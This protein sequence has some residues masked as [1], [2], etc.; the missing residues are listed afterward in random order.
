MQAQIKKFL[1]TH[2]I[3]NKTGFINLLLQ[4][5]LGK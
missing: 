5:H 2:F 4:Q 1:Q 3:F